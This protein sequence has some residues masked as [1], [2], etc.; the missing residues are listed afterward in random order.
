M[1]VENFIEEIG[2]RAVVIDETGLTK[3]RISQWVTERRIP[4]PWIK[5]L[6]E[7]YPEA[8]ARHGIEEVAA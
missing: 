6:R 5:F 4:K 7:K 3:G 8:C 2:G 1:D